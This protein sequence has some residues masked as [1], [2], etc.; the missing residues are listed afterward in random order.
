MSKLFKRLAASLLVI[1]LLM[2]GFVLAN[3]QVFGPPIGEDVPEYGSITVTR[4]IGDQHPDPVGL[5]PGALIRV[6]LVEVANPTQPTDATNTTPVLVDG[7]PVFFEGITDRNGVV[8]FSELPL[9]IWLVEELSTLTVTANTVNRDSHVVGTVLT[10]TVAGNLFPSFLVGIPRW[11]ATAD[12]WLF[13]VEV[14][15]KSD[16]P[17]Y[18]GD[19][20]NLVEVAGNLVTWEL[21]HAIPN[22]VA[23]LAHFSV[24]DMMSSGLSFVAGSVEGRFTRPGDASASW[25]DAS[26]VLNGPD[27]ET[28]HF[29]VTNVGQRVDIVITEAGQLHLAAQGLLGED[30]NVMFRL[31]T[32]IIAAG[33][34]YNRA[35]WNIGEPLDDPCF[36]DP[37][38]PECDEEPPFCVVYPELCDDIEAFYLEV[39]KQNTAR[40]NLDGAQFRMYR[41]LTAAERAA[42]ADD[43]AFIAAGG[44]SPAAGIY[45]I[46]L[47]DAAGRLVEGTTVNGV[48]DFG[49]VPMNSAGHNLWLR[50]TVAPTGYRYIDPWVQVNISRSHARPGTYI[51]DVTVFNEPAGGWNLPNTGGTGT[52]VL[53]VAGLSLV[54]GAL[55]LFAGSKK[56]KDVA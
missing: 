41:Q 30:G 15:P 20:K 54:G 50:E 18:P 27:H 28:P 6:Q 56:E 37:T 24:T 14:Y 17:E 51:V 34:Q 42:F 16:I 22:A 29:I 7:E 36:I 31:S 52:I 39:L 49:R 40:Q 33:T 3:P 38:L 45:V 35:R 8:T 53:T 44:R 9:G 55:V 11:D 10:T 32:M 48:T 4:V 13:D 25:A 1:A 46:P 43:A 26:G 47:R 12:D 21:G 23:S 19:Y 2:P 5:A